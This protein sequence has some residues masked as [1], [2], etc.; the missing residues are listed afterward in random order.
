MIMQ[1]NF[2]SGTLLYYNKKNYQM[3]DNTLTQDKPVQQISLVEM[4]EKQYRDARSI[5]NNEVRDLINLGKEMRALKLYIENKKKIDDVH[6]AL[7]SMYCL[8]YKNQ[9]VLQHY[10]SK[11]LQQLGHKLKPTR[12][13][14]N[15]AGLTEEEIEN[16]VIKEIRETGVYYQN[17][18]FPIC[19]LNELE[20]MIKV[21]K[22]IVEPEYVTFG[23]TE[24][25]SEDIRDRS[26]PTLVKMYVW[27]RDGGKCVLC[28]SNEKLEY[29]HIIPIAKGGSNTERNVQ[30]L[31]ESCN[32]RKGATIQ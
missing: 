16:F 26:I 29:D 18:A 30:L 12:P 21:L 25:E 13:L 23:T 9:N 5:I 27:Q 15:E 20:Y 28:G 10:H 8:F 24:D 17:W 31:C 1:R 32:R 22:I 11:R 2:Q 7:S 19:F 6:E 14:V 3:I 4:Y